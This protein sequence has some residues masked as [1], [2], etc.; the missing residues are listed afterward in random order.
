MGNRNDL[1]KG[2]QEVSLNPCPQGS[3]WSCASHIHLI[4]WLRV[5]PSKKMVREHVGVQPVLYGR[6]GAVISGCCGI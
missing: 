3:C 4:F 2:T 1:V 5:V 6:L